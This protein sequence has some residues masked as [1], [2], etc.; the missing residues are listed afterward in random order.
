MKTLILLSALIAAPAMAQTMY[1]CPSPQPGAPAIYQ[2]MPCTPTG[3]GEVLPVKALTSGK[4]A[5]MSDNAKAY[6]A[7]VESQRAEESR[8]AAE[9]SKRQ[10]ALRVE[11]SK[12]AAQR[13]TARA[14]DRQTAVMAAPRVITIHRRR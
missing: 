2:Q 4:G 9:E 7:D 11:R 1:K 6:L 10:E 13:E 8:L 12:A 14:I 3:G 5:G